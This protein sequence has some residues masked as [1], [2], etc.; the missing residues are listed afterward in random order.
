MFY[1]GEPVTERNLPPPHPTNI[2]QGTADIFMWKVYGLGL[3]GAMKGV[4]FNHL[5]WIDEFPDVAYTYANDFGFTADPNALVRYAE[6]EK[7][8]W[9]ELL[10]YEPIETDS[11]LSE[12][13]EVVGVEKHLP[14][15]CDSSDKYTGENKGTI[16]MV[17]LL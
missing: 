12:Y 17:P 3:R 11:A 8:I 10:S 6:D 7:N 1:K 13:F 9:F 4:I 15:I 2:E 14:I 5:T 16:E